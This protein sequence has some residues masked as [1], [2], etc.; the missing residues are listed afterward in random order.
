[1]DDA[2]AKV[3]AMDEGC[4]PNYDA[5]IATP[6]HP[7]FKLIRTHDTNTLTQQAVGGT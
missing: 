2:F 1:M 7:F 4:G 3:S 5:V 6:E